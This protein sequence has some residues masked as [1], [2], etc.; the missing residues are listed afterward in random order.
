MK[1]LRLRLQR[2]RDDRERAPL[3]LID[4]ALGRVELH[5]GASGAAELQTW[6]G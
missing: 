6:P 4:F 1:A 5:L 2:L 3:R